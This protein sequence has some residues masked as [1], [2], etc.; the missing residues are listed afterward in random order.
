MRNSVNLLCET[1]P[2]WGCF[3][4]KHRKA[5]QEG[6]QNGSSAG[7]LFVLIESQ[8]RLDITE[9]FRSDLRVTYIPSTS[10]SS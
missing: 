7:P 6:H 1:R 9:Y 4:S 3:G 10:M 5:R 2:L 8:K